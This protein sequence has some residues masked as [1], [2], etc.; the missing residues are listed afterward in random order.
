[1]VYPQILLARVRNMIRRHPVEE[2]TI[3][4]KKKK[5]SEFGQWDAAKKNLRNKKE[6]ALGLT[7]VALLSGTSRYS[8]SPLWSGVVVI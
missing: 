8:F 4:V 1:M 7:T 5:A 2:K 3:I 6:R